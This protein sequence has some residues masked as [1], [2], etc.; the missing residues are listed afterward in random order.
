VL[1]NTS[2][3]RRQPELQAVPKEHKLR[4]QLII[5]CADYIHICSSLVYDLRTN[6]STNWYRCSSRCL[7][8]LATH[9][10]WLLYIEIAC[11]LFT[12]KALVAIV[13]LKPISTICCKIAGSTEL[14]LLVVTVVW[15]QLQW[16]YSINRTHN[17][18]KTNAIQQHDRYCRTLYKLGCIPL[19][20]SLTC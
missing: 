16:V 19:S 3:W 17:S 1:T 8:T 4:H 15:L 20:Q 13:R 18:P 5:C 14:C 11:Y 7:Y 2:S 9:N 12:S 6:H 10:T